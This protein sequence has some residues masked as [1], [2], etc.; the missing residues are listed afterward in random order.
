MAKARPV[1]SDMNSL[2][3]AE[4]RRQF[5]NLLVI[6]E[7]AGTLAELQLAITQGV[8]SGAGTGGTGKEVNGVK[9]TPSHPRRPRNSVTVTMDS[10]SDY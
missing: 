10:S 9:P 6:I 7:N 4:L 5:N 8:D 3:F 2:E 1:V